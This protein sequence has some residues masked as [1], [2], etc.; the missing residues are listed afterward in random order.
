MPAHL[1]GG[2]T[3]RRV[4]PRVCD[5]FDQINAALEQRLHEGNPVQILH[6]VSHGSPGILQL[7]DI[8]ITTKL[9]LKKR[10]TIANWQLKKLALWSCSTGSDPQFV[11]V[12]ERLS[13]ADIFSAHHPLGRHPGG[14]ISSW[15]LFSR[16]GLQPPALPVHA[17]ALK[18]WSHQLLSFPVKAGGTNND[19]GQAITGLDDGSSLVAGR[20]QGSVTFGT[21]SLTSA[22]AQDVFIAKLN[23]DGTYA[24]ATQAGGTGDEQ[25][26]DITSFDDG[27]SIVTGNFSGTATFGSTTLTSAGQGDVFI[28]KLNAD[29]SYVGQFKA[30]DPNLILVTVL[31]A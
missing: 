29:G 21:T 26:R 14:K 5:P 3:V 28:A 15:Q 9:L 16:S 1:L 20:F 24:W 23:P 19:H 4:D 25:V 11:N 17:H 27:S 12:L 18:S 7:G 30:V 10:N 2:V 31:K 13:G 6:W 8:N 22:G